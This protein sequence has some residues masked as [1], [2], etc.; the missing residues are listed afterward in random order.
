MID[1][2]RHPVWK[3]VNPLKKRGHLARFF[4]ARQYAKFIPPQKIV[5]VVG[6][7]GKTTTAVAAKEVLSERFLTISTTDTNSQAANLDPIFN[8]PMTLLRAKPA[9]KKIILEL[10]IEL[11]GEMELYMSIIKPFK[12][13]VTRLSYEHN[14]FLGSLDDVLKEEAKII[15]YIPEQGSL[16]LNWDDPFSRKLADKTKSEVIFFGTDPKNC[17]VWAANIKI[18]NLRTSFELNYGVERILVQS[19][20][21]GKHQVY[22]LLAA[23]ALGVSEGLTLTTIKKGLEKVQPVEHRMESLSGYNGSIVLDDTYNAQP[24]AVEEALEVLNYIPARRRIA[25]LGEMKELGP[26]SEKMHR[27]IAKKLYNDKVDLIFLGPGDTRYIVD[28]LTKLGFIE[29][30]ICSNLQNPQLVSQ[31]LKVLA[32]GDVVLV[33]G[34]RSNRLDEVVKKIIKK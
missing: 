28:E 22:P 2:N 4:I 3:N 20:L 34:A 26:F 33:K 6:A 19:R 7:V 30:R 9:V 10:G 13:I 27:H 11:P 24:V 12:V 17:H 29:E 23:A 8:L 1:L 21:L 14:E 25:V 31:L 18:Q 5:A 16:I 32:K 15:E